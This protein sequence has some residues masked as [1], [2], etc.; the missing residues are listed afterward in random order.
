MAEDKVGPPREGV[1]EV[2]VDGQV[3][4]FSPA[5]NEVLLLN[6]TASDVWYLCS[7][8]LTTQQIADR[9]AVVYQVDRATILQDVT[10]T[11]RSF[12]EALLIGGS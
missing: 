6:Q 5:T 3:C 2:E 8:E 10:A 12:H 4:L 11:V 7:G 1:T 9:L